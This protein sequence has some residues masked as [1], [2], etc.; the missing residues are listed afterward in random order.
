MLFHYLLYLYFHVINN[1]PRIFSGNFNQPSEGIMTKI[2]HAETY[3]SLFIKPENELSELMNNAI[4]ENIST[5][6]KACNAVKNADN[7]K[8]QAKKDKNAVFKTAVKDWHFLADRDSRTHL[9]AIRRIIENSFDNVKTLQEKADNVSGNIKSVSGL[10]SAIKPVTE[11]PENKPET[12][13]ETETA[14]PDELAAIAD[15]LQEKMSIEKCYQ[16]FLELLIQN[17]HSPK[18]FWNWIEKSGTEKLDIHYQKQH[19]EKQNQ[20]NAGNEKIA[21]TA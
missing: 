5:I 13:T 3:F 14:S 9:N 19:N 10:W 17:G 1:Y 21:K 7:K 11:K 18:Q 4:R 16:N 15:M 12:K 8:Q 6:V 2:N 20:I